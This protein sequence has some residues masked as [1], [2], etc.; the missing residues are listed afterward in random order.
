MEVA[1]FD[2]SKEGHE[3]RKRICYIPD[4]PYMYDRL[5]GR[6][7]LQ[8]IG[9]LRGMKRD[10]VRRK[11]AELSEQFGAASYLDEPANS[12]SHGMKQ[13]VVV[14][15][16]LIPDPEVIFL[17]EPMVGLD[18]RLIRRFKD[19]LSERTKQGATVFMST[20][21]L[22]D[23]EEMAHRIGIIHEGKLVTEGTLAD[24]REKQ[25][26]GRLEEVFLRLTENVREG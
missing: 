26:M 17:D 15:A 1:G 21:N 3:F 5:S 11:I 22:A 10:E 6:E 14:I 23:A 16:G 2:I 25:G 4:Q 18:P 19:I 20:H 13:R 7:F 24:I 8:F 9:S 12:Y